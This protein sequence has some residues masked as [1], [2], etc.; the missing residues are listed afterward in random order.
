VPVDLVTASASG[1]IR[2]FAAAALT[3]ST[4]WKARKLDPPSSAT[5]SGRQHEGR[6]LGFPREPRVNVLA[7]NLA[8]ERSRASSRLHPPLPWREACPDWQ[9]NRFDLGEPTPMKKI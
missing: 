8:L 3:R 7:L 9:G 1:S 4:A 6:Q 2:T 5:S